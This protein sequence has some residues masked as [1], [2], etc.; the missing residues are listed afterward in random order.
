MGLASRVAREVRYMRGVVRALARVKD[1]AADSPNLIPDDWERAADRWSANTALSMD[2][3]TLTYAEADALANRYAHWALAQGLGPG[4]AV[5]LVLPNRLDYVPAWM[6]LT[7]VG[8]IAA[9]VNNHLVGSALAHCVALAAAR[10]V[11]VDPETAAALEPCRGRIGRPVTLWGLDG[12]ALDPAAGD[13]PLEPA[14]AAAPDHRPDP[15][16]RAGL[17]AGDTALYIYT[18]GTTGLPKAA[19]V[20]H[21]R[22][23]NYM[24]GFAGSTGATPRDRVFIVLPLYH[25]TGGLCGVG[26]ALMAGGTAVIRRRFKASTFWSEVNAEGATLFV[27][28]GEL[29]R[30]MVNQREREGERTH[31]IRLAFGNGLRPE[32][33]ERFTSRFAIPHV[34]EFYGATE[35]NVSIL[36]F[37]GRPG[38][39]GR[40]APYIRSKFNVRL[41]RFDLEAEQ[42]VRGPDGF[43]VPCPPGEVGE[44]LGEITS[45]PR[46]QYTGYADPEASA[47]K[48]LTDVFKPGDRWFRTGDLMRQD[49]DGYFYFVDRVGD[50]FRWK[51]ENVSTNEVAE[52]LGAAP[53]VCEVNVYGV[54]VPGCDGRAGMASLVV[55]PEFDPAALA[56]HVDAELPAYARPLFLRLR[57]EM[58]TTGTFKYRKA[59]LVADGFDPAR[60]KDPL[61]FRDGRSGYVPLGAALYARLLAGEVRL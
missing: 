48:V 44:A 34:L 36:N 38:S 16:R 25:A 7:K 30:Y 3:R 31:K 10:H 35:G 60:V 5:A 56:A 49:R 26:A 58:E 1:V 42:P 45:Q 28:V 40:V 14:L 20:A 54:E 43:C 19:K 4:D 41:V 27:Y 13:Q 55:A 61:F 37:D 32:V 9:L 39:V 59:D 17:V 50:T 53:G 33:W 2:G 51:G 22:V 52:V 8:V 6:G 23:Q 12:A 11:I 57:P 15:A 24:R 47:K 21:V 29:C 18:S 46:S